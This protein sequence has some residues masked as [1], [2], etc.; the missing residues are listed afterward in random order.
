V[1]SNQNRAL[2]RGIQITTNIEAI[3]WNVARSTAVIPI[4][5]GSEK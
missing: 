4:L 1:L 3:D 5:T 2:D